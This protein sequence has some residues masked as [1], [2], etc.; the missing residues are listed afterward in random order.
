M[1]DIGLAHARRSQKGP[2]EEREE[3][4]WKVIMHDPDRFYPKT[5]SLH[6]AICKLPAFLTA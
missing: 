3:K 2:A 4:E 5:C 6:T 1:I